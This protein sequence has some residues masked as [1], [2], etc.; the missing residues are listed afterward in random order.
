MKSYQSKLGRNIY[1]KQC[2]RCAGDLSTGSDHYGRYI[3]CLQCGYMA[4]IE[5]SNQR[6]VR[7]L[8]VGKGKVA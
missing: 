3:H 6:D 8:S 7:S 1:L 5:F 2:P 4:D